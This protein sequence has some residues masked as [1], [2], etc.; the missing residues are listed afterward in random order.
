LAGTSAAVAPTK[1][2]TGLGAPQH[3]ISRETTMATI[4]AKGPIG[5]TID[6]LDGVTNSADTIVGTNDMDHIEGLGGDDII[7]GGGGADFIYG[8]E[9]RDTVTYENSFA[10][11]EVNL[12]T[13]KGYG[14]EATG[15]HL[16][17][18][19]DLF[20][21]MH[22]DKLIGNGK[23]NT[24]NGA[25]GNDTLKGGGGADKLIGGTGNDIIEIDGKDDIVDGGADNDTLVVKSN[26]GLEINLTTGQINEN[27]NGAGISLNYGYSSPFY[28]GPG[29]Q[30]PSPHDWTQTE[31]TDVEN[32]LGSAYDDDIYGNDLA[33]SL[34][35]NGGNDVLSGGEGDDI[36]DGGS[37]NDKIAGGIGADIMSGGADSDTFIF[38]NLDASRMVDGKP[39][40]LITDF[41]QGQ[42]KIDLSGASFAAGPLLVLN[43]QNVDGTNYSYVGIDEN[44]NQML[45]EGEFA[46]A[47]QVSAGTVLNYND[48]L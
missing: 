29:Q 38:W 20:G 23:S 12:K 25:A 39:Q 43:N 15:D 45:D 42:D 35:G 4:I 41:E 40:D 22:A 47:V 5:Q 37:G 32:V 24:L 3:A 9:G 28:D 36:L 21:S 27:I 34:S 46:I 16:D 10:G 2:R 30:K 6:E 13:G 19:E 18:I 11:V 26:K 7:K 14:G 17:S 1:N 48:F 44:N 8:G 33:N 31:V